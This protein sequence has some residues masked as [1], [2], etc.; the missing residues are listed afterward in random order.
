MIPASTYLAERHMHMV[1]PGA[2]H[3]HV[4]LKALLE[5][6]QPSDWHGEALCGDPALIMPGLEPFL[7]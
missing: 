6:V 3:H 4:A 7:V 5:L 1:W 2:L